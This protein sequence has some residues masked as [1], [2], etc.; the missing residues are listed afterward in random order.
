MILLSAPQP[1]LDEI[2]IALR[3]FDTPLRLLLEAVQDIDRIAESY[4][5]HGAVGVPVEV[6]DQ[7]DRSAT[8]SLQ[9]L[10]RRRVLAVCTKYSSKP[11]LS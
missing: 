5:V 8:E 3:R 1:S 2:D 7:F 4:R 6:F 11:K 9:R 10:G